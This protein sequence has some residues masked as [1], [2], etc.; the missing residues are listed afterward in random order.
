MCKM[1]C[2]N[3]NE[4]NEKH[5]ENQNFH[6]AGECRQLV[7]PQFF[8]VANK[9]LVNHTIKTVEVQDMDHCEW[10][11][12][13]EPD[14]VSVNFEIGTQQCDLNNATH[15]NH[16]AE[17]EDKD[18]FLYHGADS[19]CETDPCQNGGVCQSGYTDKGYRCV[20]PTGFTSDQCEKDVDECSEEKHNCSREANCTNIE[21]SY[22]CTCK[23]G[24]FGDGQK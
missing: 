1:Q 9:R 14:C 18:G 6:F 19:A 23:E 10:M 12:Y 17:L 24:F 7:F 2:R 15:R 11:C 22:H 3:S 20:C 16:G 21:G 13:K 5:I 8:F 4:G